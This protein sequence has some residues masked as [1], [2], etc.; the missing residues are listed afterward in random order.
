ML[1]RH[2][3]TNA[4]LQTQSASGNSPRSYC[5]G[6]GVALG[7]DVDELADAAG[8]AGEAEDV[9]EAAVEGAESFFSSVLVVLVSVPV[10]DGGLSLSE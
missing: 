3:Q 6:E 4:L 10:P 1:P 9:V 2:R 5:E 8:V 7:V